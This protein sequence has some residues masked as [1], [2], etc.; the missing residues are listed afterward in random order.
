L[1]FGKTLS[2]TLEYLI[3]ERGIN[4][5]QLHKYTG[6]SLST[7]RRLRLNKEN[8]PTLASLVPIAKYFSITVD[9]LI[10][11]QPLEE[12]LAV[13][14]FTVPKLEATKVP[15]IAWENTLKCNKARQEQALSSLL[16]SDVY[17]SKAAYALI[18]KKSQWNNLLAGSL[19]VIDPQLEFNDR[20]FIIV[21]EKTQQFPQLYQV[22][23]FEKKNYLKLSDFNAEIIPFTNNY[24]NL[25]VV[26]QIRTNYK[27]DRTHV[28]TKD[29]E[30]LYSTK[31][32]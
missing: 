2:A 1:Y 27:N 29:Q 26:T 8:N 28:N 18:I 13:S 25:G 30:F 16:I 32:Y 17:L 31:K 6:I 14:K 10:G 9:Q 7:L 15:I 3:K 5:Q 11:I 20:D 23:I 21:S 22:L 24:K 12:R 4:T 19:L